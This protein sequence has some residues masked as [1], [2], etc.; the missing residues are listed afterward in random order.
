MIQW[1]P[2]KP[3]DFDMSFLWGTLD[4]QFTVTTCHFWQSD[5]TSKHQVIFWGYGYVLKFLDPRFLPQLYR[6]PPM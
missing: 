3:S 1:K 4:H 5:Y 6:C 2:S